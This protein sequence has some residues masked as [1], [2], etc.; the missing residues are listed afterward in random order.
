MSK[1]TDLKTK[2]LGMPIG[3][4]SNKLR[5]SILWKYIVLSGDNFC[6]Q[7]G[8]EIISQD[9]LSIEHKIPWLHSKDPLSLFM[10]LDNIAFSHL[11]C[12]V[13]AARKQQAPHG[14]PTKY[15]KGCRCDLCRVANAA[16]A[17][18]DY[19]TDKR[20]EKYLRSGH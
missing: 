17:K 18:K 2:Q 8:S 16:R 11:S 10:D 1:N 7:C 19:T 6:F 12:N 13:G 9:D 4:A 20:R 3:T 5:K 14:T 15:N